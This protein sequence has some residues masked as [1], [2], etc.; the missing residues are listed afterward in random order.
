MK[1]ALE[2]AGMTVTVDADTSEF[3][4]EGLA[5]YDAIVMFQT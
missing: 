5:Q 4:D 1:A 2:A 3:N